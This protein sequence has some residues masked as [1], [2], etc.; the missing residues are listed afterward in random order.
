MKATFM[1]AELLA[2]AAIGVGAV[3]AHEYY[4]AH[5]A[6]SA[7]SLVEDCENMT[8][9]YGTTESMR[10]A[11]YEEWQNTS[12]YDA[13]ASIAGDPINVPRGLHAYNK[14]LAQETSFD[15]NTPLTAGTPLGLTVGGI[16][17]LILKRREQKQTAEELHS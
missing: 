8:P 10:Q 11:C 14:T 3:S 12:S 15:W 9:I 5:E 1:A 13:L 7:L 6:R 4:E 2:S 16:G 17:L